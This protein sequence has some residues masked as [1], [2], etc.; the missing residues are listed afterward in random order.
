MPVTSVLVPR[1]SNT[2]PPVPVLPVRTVGPTG[3]TGPAG[4]VTVTVTTAKV[5]AGGNTGSM[6]F[7]NGLLTTQVQA[8]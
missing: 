1:L 7:T 2:F 5:T 3:P 8:T 4:G 6:I